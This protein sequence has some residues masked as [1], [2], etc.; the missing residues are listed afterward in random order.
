[1]QKLAALLVALTVGCQLEA[2][3]PTLAPIVGMDAELETET[4]AALQLWRDAT[5]G[6]FAPETHIGCTGGEDVCIQ[7][8]EG[9]VSECDGQ[10]D[11]LACTTTHG[12]AVKLGFVESM[13]LV[14]VGA[15]QLGTEIP[16]DQQVGTLAH[17]FGHYLGLEHSDRGLMNPTRPESERRSAC[18]DVS[19]LDAFAAARSVDRGGLSVVCFG[20]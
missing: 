19:T 6:A 13:D 8:V 4:L 9:R 14:H 3:E 2:P 7:V 1:M 11:R 5:G 16:A 12:L 10:P 15:M 18:I 17:E 20:R